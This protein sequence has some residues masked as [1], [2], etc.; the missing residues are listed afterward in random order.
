LSQLYDF[1]FLPCRR[2]LMPSVCHSHIR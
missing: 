2:M 1:I